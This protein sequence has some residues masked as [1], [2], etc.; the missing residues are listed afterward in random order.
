[1]AQRRVCV[2]VTDEPGMV[3]VMTDGSETGLCDGVTDEPG[4]VRVMTDGS[5]TGLCLC[6]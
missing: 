6:Y 2:C 1:M 4:M 3:R 5:E